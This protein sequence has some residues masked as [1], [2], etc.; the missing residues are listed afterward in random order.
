LAS[1]HTEGDEMQAEG[2]TNY[3]FLIEIGEL[4]I[5]HFGD[6]GQEALTDEQLEILG[7]IDILITQ[8]VNPFSRMDVRNEIGFNLAAQVN[9]KLIIP[10]HYNLDALEISVGQWESFKVDETV[11]TIDSTMLVEG[12]TRLLLFS[13]YGKAA[14]NL[15]QVPDWST[16]VSAE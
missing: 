3:I 10:T 4:R 12:E 5:A 13:L 6:I 2:G 16:A 8:F 1:A 11:A 7:D 9:P 15:Y 14:A